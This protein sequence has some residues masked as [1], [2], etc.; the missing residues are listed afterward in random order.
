MGVMVSL[1]DEI[2]NRLQTAIGTGKDLADVKRVLVGSHEEARKMNDY[3]VIN[4][5]LISGEE[6]PTATRKYVDKMQVEVKLITNKLVYKDGDTNNN[7]LFNTSLETGALYLFEKMLNV[8]DKNTSDELDF[9]FAT[10]SNNL[11]LFNYDIETINSVYEFTLTIE[12][13]TEEF[14]G[15]SRWKIG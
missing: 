3:P 15:G 1:L 14:Q 4:I 12:I 7:L 6:I 13:E 5:T 9:D 2:R 8:L 11:R 10:S